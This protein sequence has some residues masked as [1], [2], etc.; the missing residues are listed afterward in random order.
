LFA[1]DKRT[2]VLGSAVYAFEQTCPDRLDL[3]HRHFRLLCR[4][5]ADVDEWLVLIICHFY[6]LIFL[7]SL[8]T[9]IYLI[10]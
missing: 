3:L 2:L 4:A 9:C 6:N 10:I 1:G 5:L 7:N 8:N